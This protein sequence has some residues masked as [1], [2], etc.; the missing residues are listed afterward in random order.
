MNDQEL[1]NE[2]PFH[3]R[4]IIQP[5]RQAIFS[6]LHVNREARAVWIRR[7]FQ[8]PRREQM[9]GLNIQFDTPF[10]SYDTDIFTVFDGWPLDGLDNGI[11]TGDNVVDG[12]IGLDRSRIRNIAVY[13]HPKTVARVASAISI[14]TLPNLEV[15][16]IL[17]MGPCIY[18]PYKPTAY[19]DRVGSISLDGYEM[20]V[21]DAQRT[22]CEIHDLSIEVVQNHSVFNHSRLFHPGAS[23][24]P[25]LGHRTHVMSW[26]W[27]D[28]QAKHQ[29]KAAGQIAES[30]WSWLNYMLENDEEGEEKI[31][32][33][34]LD[35]CG[36]EGHTKREMRE[37]ECP[38]IVDHKILYADIWQDVLKTA[39]IM[40]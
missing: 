8:P 32:P 14:N 24:Y 39:E 12:F 13:E 23:L 7:F 35:G 25:L 34:S 20:L 4:Y 11:A 1:T 2:H 17:S 19:R 10:I 21:V 28:M 36:E 30:W 16:T 29:N 37:W 22:S 31:C 18:S 15:F 3:Y 6:P 33:L 27:H 26:L 38:F 9:S 40:C 5:K